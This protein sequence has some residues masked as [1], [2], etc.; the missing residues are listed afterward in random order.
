MLNMP[1]LAPFPTFENVCLNYSAAIFTIIRR[2]NRDATVEKDL[3][4]EVLLKMWRNWSTFNRDRGAL[5]TWISIITTHTCIDHFR[6]TRRMKQLDQ[7]DPDL[8]AAAKLPG[9]ADPAIH[10]HE[11]MRLACILSPGQ[12]DVIVTIYFKGHTQNEASRLLKVPLGTV[13]SRQRSALLSLRKMYDVV[14]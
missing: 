2:F 1:T 11:L 14:F 4:Q 7:Q 3:H 9:E 5:F 6:K 12:R 13:K 8:E 10:R